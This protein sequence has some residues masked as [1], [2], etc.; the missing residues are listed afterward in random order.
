MLHY[1]IILASFSNLLYAL[2]KSE[3]SLEMMYVVKF[4][5]FTN[6]QF[7]SVTLQHTKMLRPYVYKATQ[8]TTKQTYSAFF[9]RHNKEICFYIFLQDVLTAFATSVAYT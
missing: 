1:S 9:Q 3:E 7:I 5:I 2:S 4:C 6:H 8:K